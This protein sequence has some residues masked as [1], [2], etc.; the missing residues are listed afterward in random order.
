MSKDLKKG[1]LGQTAASKRKSLVVWAIT[2]AALAGGGY[3][4]ISTREQPK[5]KFL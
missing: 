1:R 5:W 4:A 2:A 3:A